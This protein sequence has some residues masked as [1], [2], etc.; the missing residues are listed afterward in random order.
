MKKQRERT[1][2]VGPG[3][4]G[5]IFSSFHAHG[6]DGLVPVSD[7]CWMLHFVLRMSRMQ[8]VWCFQKFLIS[9]SPRS[10]VGVDI[11][12]VSSASG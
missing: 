2:G 9:R 7:E 11:H 12:S 8:P 3:R 1:D 10:S 4:L 6:K 5:G